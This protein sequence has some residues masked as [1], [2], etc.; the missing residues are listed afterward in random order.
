A[1]AGG[2]AVGARQAPRRL[3]PVPGGCERGAGVEYRR[4]RATL[5]GRNE[6]RVRR[7]CRADDERHDQERAPSDQLHTGPPTSARPRA[8]SCWDRSVDSPCGQEL[9]TPTV[10]ELPGSRI[11]VNIADRTDGIKRNNPR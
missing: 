6:D 9:C 1:V 2:I 7:Q 5:L 8:P 4:A 11:A 10:D 3:G